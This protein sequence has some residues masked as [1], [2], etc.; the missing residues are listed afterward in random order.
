MSLEN[1][2]EGVLFYK[3]EP[4]KKTVFMEL[5]D[6]KEAVLNEACVSLEKRLLSGATRL[7]ITDSELQLVVAPELSELIDSIRKDELKKDIGSA[8]AEALAIILYRGPLS[9]ADID[10]VR[11]VNST[12]IIRSLLVRGLIERR[13]HPTHKQS[14]TYAITPALLNHLGIQKREELPQF[15]EIMDALDTYEKEHEEIEHTDKNIF[16]QQL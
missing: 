14:F 6:V 13:S 12:F 10:R 2:I 16:E 9:R 7:V 1:H 5:F 11:G 4:V 3:A 8:G 15:S